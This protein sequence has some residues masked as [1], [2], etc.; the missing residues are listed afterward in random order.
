[1]RTALFS[2][3]L[4]CCTYTILGQQAFTV[5]GLV[6]D[7][8]SKELLSTVSVKLRKVSDTIAMDAVTGDNGRFVFNNLV[9]G[10]YIFHISHVGY[11]SV[12]KEIVLHG[13]DHLAITLVRSN[14]ILS[15][16]TVL[17]DKKL[18]TH[19]QEKIIYNVSEGAVTASDNLYN[20]ILKIPGVSESNNSLFYQGKPLTILLDGKSNNMSGE[21]MKNFLSGMLGTNID[22]LEVLLNPSARYDAQ[23]GAVFN[24]RSLRN[25]NYGL[26]EN[27]T[28]GSGTGSFF[29]YN[30]GINL[31]YRDSNI[32]IYG[33]YDF[34]HQKQFFLLKALIGFNTSP[35]VIYLVDDNVRTNNNHAVRF[36]IDYD[37][38]KKTSL[39]L[40]FKGFQNYRK[41]A[42]VNNSV[43]SPGNNIMDTVVEVITKTDALFK[44]P[45]L[46]LFF[47]TKLFSK[48]AD[49]LLNVDYFGFHKKWD[50]DFNTTYQDKQGNIVASPGYLLNRSPADNS[51][52]SLTAD[53]YQPIKNG[54]L[55]I[56]AKITDSKTDNDVLWQQRVN[57]TWQTD[58]GKTNHFI[59]QEDI[60]AAYINMSKS[61]KK[62]TFQT[63]LRFEATRATG[64]SL[65]TSLKTLNKYNDFFPS[66]SFNYKPG[67]DQQFSITY[68]KSVT[69]FGFDI[70]NPFI[71][72]QGPYSYHQ[73]NPYIKPSY[74]SSINASW[75][76]K[77]KLIIS[78]GFSDVKNPISYGY[79]KYG[80]T[81]ASLGS[82]L[83]FSS[84]N[85]YSS[86]ISYIAKLLKGKW[87]STNSVNFL[88]SELPDFYSRIQKNNNYALSTI[89][90]V[91]LPK[92]ITI[93]L[94]GFYKSQI[95]DGTVLQSAN[96]G[97]SAGISKPVLKSRGTLRLSCTDLFDTQ[98]FHNRTQGDGIKIDAYWKPESRFVNLLFTYRFGNLHVKA[99]RNRRTGIEDERSRMGAN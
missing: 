18:V 73:G 3:V 57:N 49:F 46:N 29:R 17:S 96:Y 61:Y 80:N 97:I 72:I 22:K 11:Q 71:I 86:S 82:W 65:T 43:Y 51:V 12:N 47:K 83:N 42:V 30:A 64:K 7:S 38:N 79:K 10:K 28:I 74:F 75:A 14:S 40:L 56:G 16:V 2:L 94:S 81:D 48:G 13:D 8:I 1:M 84:G 93:E 87:T 5:S 92:N 66:V 32:N 4:T 52:K 26:T 90:N 78:A 33:G 9:S 15:N 77:N 95:L 35:T 53:F 6:S 19:T 76:Y 88:R 54:N 27:I 39:G 55:E 67:K 37:L 70:M 36:G 50:E 58:A 31:N 34:N 41:R 68:R 98:I 85:L 24:L 59:Y 91:L 25:K 21:D 60:Y 62:I 45:S 63:G 89:N 44:S 99:N 20:T 69:R 23:S